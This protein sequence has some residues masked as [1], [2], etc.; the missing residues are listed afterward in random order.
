MALRKYLGVIRTDKSGS[1]TEFEFE[2]D[3]DALPTAPQA[4]TD[5]LE[6]L[7]RDAMWGSGLLELSFWEASS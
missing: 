5:A 1:E 3:D 6:T 2:V 7:A 4:R